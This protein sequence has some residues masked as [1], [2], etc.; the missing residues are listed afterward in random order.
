[1]AETDGAPPK[2]LV[3][4]DARGAR[5]LSWL[6]GRFESSKLIAFS[7]LFPS[8]VKKPI[9]LTRTALD[10]TGDGIDEWLVPF[11]SGYAVRT[12]DGTMHNVVSDIESGISSD[13]HVKI[14]HKL[15]AQHPFQLPGDPNQGLAFLSEKYVD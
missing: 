11:P 2:E 1:F 7:S 15:P 9:F 6:D 3:T 14:G 5:I 8:N 13:D 12:P 10:L 4:V